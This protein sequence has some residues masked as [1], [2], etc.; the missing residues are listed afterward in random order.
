MLRLKPAVASAESSTATA[1]LRT[2]STRRACCAATEVLVWRSVV[3]RSAVMVQ[4]TQT[5]AMPATPFATSS[6]EIRRIV[7]LRTIDHSVSALPFGAH[8]PPRAA[9]VSERTL[10]RRGPLAEFTQSDV[11][12]RSV[13]IFV[14][15]NGL[16]VR[17]V[18]TMRADSREGLMHGAGHPAQVP[19]VQHC[20]IRARRPGQC[21]S[22]E[23]ARHPGVSDHSDTA[24][25]RLPTVG[26][27]TCS[28][29]RIGVTGTRIRLS[30][31]GGAVEGEPVVR[32]RLNRDKLS[33]LRR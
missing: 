2:D 19:D 18:P 20:R 32:F 30:N 14:E 5:A 6:R 31:G 24:L 1:T 9:N 16:A 28:Q 4:P 3:S 7:T 25:T 15:A 13:T 17:N 29:A 23:A 11:V 10:W 12:T 21:G 22:G 27:G 33:S 26:G 8:I